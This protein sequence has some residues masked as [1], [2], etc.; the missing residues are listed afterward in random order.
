MFFASDTEVRFTKH[1][2]IEI[3]EVGLSCNYDLMI[4]LKVQLRYFTFL[5]QNPLQSYCFFTSPYGNVMLE[6]IK[7]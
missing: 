5:K 3:F 7:V 6:L 1:N 2:G 4:Q